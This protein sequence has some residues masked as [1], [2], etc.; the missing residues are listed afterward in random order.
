MRMARR[1][2]EDE[3]FAIILPRY[4]SLMRSR[5]DALKLA[6]LFA[7][8]AIWLEYS[9]ERV[10]EIARLPESQ[11]VEVIRCHMELRARAALACWLEAKG[12]VGKA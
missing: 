1:V 11:L 6:Q 8:D 5:E 2:T 3:A 4:S 12:K 10:E 9:R 7:R